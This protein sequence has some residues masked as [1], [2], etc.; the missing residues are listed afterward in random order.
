MFEVSQA[1]GKWRHILQELGVPET[2]LTGRNCPCPLCGGKDRFRFTDKNGDGLWICNQ[3]GTGNGMKLVME[4]R[5]VDFPQAIRLV[6]SVAGT[7]KEIAKQKKYSHGWWV[8]K[9]WRE[10]IAVTAGDPV[11]EY[12]I[13]RGIKCEIPH[14]IRLIPA[15]EYFHDGKTIGTF[16]AMACIVRDH[17]GEPKTLHVTYLKNGKKAVLP[18]PK[19]VLS[20]MG[21]SAAIRLYRN[22]FTLCVTEGIETALAVREITNMAVW[23][24][25]SAG[26]LKS[27]V[28][29]P[30]V[31]HLEVWA[32]NDTN[33]TGQK[34]AYALANEMVIKRKMNV[35]VFLPNNEG[36]DWADGVNMWKM[37]EFRAANAG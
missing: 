27:F 8:K 13:G 28:P 33:F 36:T 26:N 25:I 18:S 22:D 31:T 4:V 23:S 5:G 7:I 24:L 32:D 14:T 9:I 29:P 19:K 12:L 1:N 15:L 11:S 10:S 17:A 37:T 6:E 16:A 3:C 30:E 21:E 35:K 34:C 2:F 20:E